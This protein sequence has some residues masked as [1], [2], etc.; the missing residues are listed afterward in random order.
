ML[1]TFSAVSLGMM[2]QFEKLADPSDDVV[3]RG[4]AVRGLRRAWADNR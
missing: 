4:E 3:G 1:L 2:P